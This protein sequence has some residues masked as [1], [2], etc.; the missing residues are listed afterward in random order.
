MNTKG[1]YDHWTAEQTNW[2]AGLLEGEGC[3]VNAPRKH[4]SNKQI[5]TSGLVKLTMT[6]ADVVFDFAELVESRISVLKEAPPRQKTAYAV[7]VSGVRARQLME[8]I[9]PLMHT[10]RAKKIIEILIVP[11]WGF[12]DSSKDAARSARLRLTGNL[13]M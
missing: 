5:G 4:K 11:T 3:F 13:D 6:D 12:P 2:V 7:Q 8:K 1:L 10:R 9:L